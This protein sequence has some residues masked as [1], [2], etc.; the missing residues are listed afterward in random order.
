M[1]PLTN[2]ETSAPAQV[3]SSYTIPDSSAVYMSLSTNFAVYQNDVKISGSLSPSLAGEN[4]TLYISSMGSPLVMLATVET[5]ANGEYSHRWEAPPGGIYSVRAN[6]SGDEDYSGADSST[7]SLVVVPS[8]LVMVGITLIVFLV[9]LLV[10]TLATK[11]DTSEKQ[12]SFED[13]D[14]ADYPEDF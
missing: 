6:W 7:F 1:I 11:E 14:F 13:W 2:Y 12:E 9:V 4:V 5:D 8:E 10:V 3:S